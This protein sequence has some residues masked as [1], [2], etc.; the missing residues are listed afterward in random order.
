MM[1]ESLKH[2]VLQRLLI[3]IPHMSAL[4]T[5]GTH[6]KWIYHTNPVPPVAR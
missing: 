2:S 1:T 3:R 5:P 4:F 6:S